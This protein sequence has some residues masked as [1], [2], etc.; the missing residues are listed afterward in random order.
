MRANPLR[1][2]FLSHFPGR[3]RPH[4]RDHFL[5]QGLESVPV[6]PCEH[7]DRD[8]GNALVTVVERVITREP[9]A[10]GRSEFC[11]IGLGVVCEAIPGPGK[12]RFQARVVAQTGHPSVYADEIQLQRL[13]CLF[14]QPKRL[15]RRRHVRLLRQLPQG[16]AILLHH[17]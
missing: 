7:G 13:N 8:E 9:E 3:Q 10:V 17:L 6:Q 1:E 15:R 2:G 16:I 14:T 12:G 4:H 11:R 5:L